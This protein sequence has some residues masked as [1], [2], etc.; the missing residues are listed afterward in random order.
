MHRTKKSWN[1]DEAVTTSRNVTV[2]GRFFGEKYT[3]STHGESRECPPGGFISLTQVT[4]SRCS[5][6]ALLLRY[7]RVSHRNPVASPQKWTRPVWR[8]GFPSWHSTW[9]WQGGWH[10]IGD[11]FWFTHSRPKYLK[12]HCVLSGSRHRKTLLQINNEE[13]IV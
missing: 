3:M 5:T 9:K 8:R 7:P 12:V 10:D 13:N 4:Y 11:T 2:I 1:F 6:C